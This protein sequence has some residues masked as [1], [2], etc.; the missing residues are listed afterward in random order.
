[1]IWVNN[2]NQDKSHNPC[3]I[4]VKFFENRVEILKLPLAFFIN[5]YSSKVH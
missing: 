3:S 5:L 1:M 2:V 4:P